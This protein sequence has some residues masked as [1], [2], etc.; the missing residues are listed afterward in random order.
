VE[1]EVL[2]LSRNSTRVA[3]LKHYAERVRHLTI[4]RQALPDTSTKGTTMGL[5]EEKFE[6]FEAFTLDDA[7]LDAMIVGLQSD[8]PLAQLSHSD[9]RK[10]F[11][12]MEE[13]GYLVGKEV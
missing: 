6:D 11:D 12:R 8:T 4:N 1:S 10:V 9:A 2:F 5:P 7:Q 13:L 3:E